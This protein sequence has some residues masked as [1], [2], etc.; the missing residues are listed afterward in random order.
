MGVGVS[1]NERLLG[2]PELR[3]GSR[4]E[5]EVAAGAVFVCARVS[6]RA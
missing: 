2:L 6:T 5:L 3:M 4:M 1:V